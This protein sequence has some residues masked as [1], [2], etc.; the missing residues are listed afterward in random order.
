MSSCGSSGLGASASMVIRTY[1]SWARSSNGIASSTAFA[2][3]GSL[4][5][6][7]EIE[8]HCR[9]HDATKL[10][11]V[12]EPSIGHHQGDGIGRES[13][14]HAAKLVGRRRS[15]PFGEQQDVISALAEGRN[16]HPCAGDPVIEVPAEAP[17][18]HLG[19]E[20]AIR[21]R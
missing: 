3:D 1:I 16:S 7:I 12:A 17:C 9:L 20:T 21:H 5:Q 6:M 4:P 14:R 15:E 2:V 18:L 19:T 13:D 10:T 11:A 8:R